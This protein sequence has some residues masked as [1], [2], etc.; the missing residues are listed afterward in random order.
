MII[1][2]ENE[3]KMLHIQINIFSLIF[4]RWGCKQEE[5]AKEE[6]FKKTANKHSNF[7]VKNS[8]L[9]VTPKFPYL[10]ASPDGIIHCDC[11]GTGSLEVKCPFSAIKTKLKDAATQKNFCLE[12]CDGELKLRRNHDYFFQVQ[13]QIQLTGSAYCD[14]CVWTPQEIYIQRIL[15][16]EKFFTECVAKATTFFKYG[17]LPELLGKWFTRKTMLELTDDSDN[18]DENNQ[19][20]CYCRKPEE[21]SMIGCD[22]KDCP[23]QWYHTVCLKIKRVPK[24]KWFCPDCRKT[25]R[26]E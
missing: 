7:S 15:P 13:P 24:G 25:R 21:G 10:G 17:V 23:I 18:N 16:D 26:K 4:F 20:W 5:K 12:L 1:S 9:I 14:F 11:C 6:Y 8:G 3:I 2:V 19:R 22:N